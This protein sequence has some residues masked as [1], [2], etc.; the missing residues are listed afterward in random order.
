MNHRLIFAVLS[1]SLPLTGM[2]E[3][4]RWTDAT[5]QVHYGQTPPA[6]GQYQVVHPADTS[7][8]SPGL[9]KFVDQA[10]KAN[11]EAEKAHQ[12]ELK[13][14]AESAERCAKAR[15]RVSMLESHGPH[16]M[17]IPGASSTAEPARMT[18]EEFSKRLASAQ[19]EEADSCH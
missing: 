18:D 5:G 2:A 8:L 7:G 11:A 17:F 19:K 13:S 10:D 1:L 14:K 4:Y 12:A 9:T 3:I 15:E 6:Q 16:R